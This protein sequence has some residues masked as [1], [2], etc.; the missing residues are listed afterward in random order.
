MWFIQTYR[1]LTTRIRY[2]LPD[3]SGKKDGRKLFDTADQFLFFGQES[4]VITI[5]KL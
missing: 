2:C 1:L 5:N 3:L 4:K